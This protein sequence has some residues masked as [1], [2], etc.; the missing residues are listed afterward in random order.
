VAMLCF[1]SL[2]LMI[3][4]KE[5]KPAVTVLNV[6]MLLFLLS[7]T[8]STFIG[9]D[10]YHSF[11]DNHERMLG[12][13]TIIHYVIF[14]FISVSV[15]KG[16]KDWQKALRV[17]LVAGSLV[18]LVGIIQF[19]K[20]DFL[21]N[22]DKSRVI[23]TL[24][25]A[26]YV[27]GYGMF[28]TFVAIL[29]LAKETVR[30]WKLAEAVMG[31]LAFINIF[32][33]GTRGSL[34]G[35]IVSILFALITYAIL[36]R[37]NRK[38]R[39][40]TVVAGSVVVLM[41]TLLITFRHSS[42]VGNIPAVGRLLSTP[43]DEF[44][45]SGRSYAW[46]GAVLSVKDHP[47]FGWG[48]NN[49][50]Y[51]YNKYY[52]PKALN[53]GYSETWF[54]NAH[55]II[56]NTL[57]VQG[58]FG[59]ASYLF[60]FI[61]GCI[62]LIRAYA[63]KDI[64]REVMVIG[65]TFL[66]AHFVHNITVFEDPTSY[67]YFIFWLAL[68][69]GLTA[70]KN[71]SEVVVTDTKPNVISV[72]IVGAL[73]VLF[74]Y[75]CNV[76]PARANQNAL[77]VLRIMGADPTQGI[78]S[79][80]NAYNS[81]SPHIDDIRNDIGRS[82]ISA[83][84]SRYK[85]LGVEKSE[86]LFLATESALKSNIELHPMDIRVH[87][88]L[89]QLLQNQASLT[90]NTK[91]FVEANSY[92]EEALRFSPHRQQVLYTLAMNYLPLNKFKEAMSLLEGSIKDNPKI[93]EGYWRLAYVYRVFNQFDKAQETIDKAKKDGIIFTE[94]EMNIVNQILTKPPVTIKASSSK[95]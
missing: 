71:Q 7:F 85:D 87:L 77:D 42:F 47:I 23:A 78:I 54:D 72:G 17:F 59:L 40:I 61:A 76:Q 64:G 22:T 90:N 50:F 75:I 19:F 58:I 20:P 37:E 11:W 24:G 36:L 63:K 51:A 45:S 35:L 57:S 28:L 14:Y 18:M 60:I 93:S 13:F 53:F 12:L 92:L 69:N 1:Y 95:K 89:A 88:L 66:V 91:Y 68:I 41:L 38:A 65:L 48:P 55:N 39:V 46:R 26:I 16:W 67:L 31:F 32:L 3:N 30:N 70:S 44:L 94:S 2:L 83:L 86:E 29:L 73:G 9:V 5:F 79:V 82:V 15:F 27:G 52:D 62:S 33:S 84:G 4:W 21:L 6:A 43:I 74:I 34:L 10:P 49:F 8:V 81:P 56:L 25:N 80:K